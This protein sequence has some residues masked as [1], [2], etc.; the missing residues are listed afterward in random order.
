MLVDKM[1]WQKMA[2][3]ALSS[4]LLD[5]MY[6]NLNMF[7]YHAIVSQFQHVWEFTEN[8]YDSDSIND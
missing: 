1:P 8:A 6:I 4:Y 3:E 5:N 2:N 7:H